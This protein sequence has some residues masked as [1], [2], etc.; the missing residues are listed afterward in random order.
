MWMIDERRRV[1]RRGMPPEIRTLVEELRAIAR[2][3]GSQTQDGVEWRA[4]RKGTITLLIDV[5]VRT[6]RVDEP[7]E[8]P[9][10]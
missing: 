4:I 10:S 8:P 1:E 2:S 3:P 6:W 9:P 5:L 7:R